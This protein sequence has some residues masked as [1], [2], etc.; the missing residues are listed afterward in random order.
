M[1]EYALILIGN[2]QICPL[3]DE[4]QTIAARYL[5]RAQDGQW[6]SEGEAYLAPFE[7]AEED[8]SA[9]DGHIR[10]HYQDLPIDIAIRPKNELKK[11]LLI[12][13]MDSTIIQQECIDEIADF[14]GLKERIS[15][16]TEQAMRGELD[17]DAAL[18]ERVSLL[19]GIKETALQ[20]VI[21]QKLDL[22][23]GAK[24]LVQTMKA[25]DCYCALVSGGFTFFTKRIAETVGFHTN[26]A[27]QLKIENGELSGEVLEPILGREAKLS[28]LKQFCTE[29]N[30]SLDEAL[31][32]G[33]GAND[34]AMI[35]AAGLGVAFH[36]KPIVAEKADAQINSGDLT[37]LLFM[38]GYNREEFV[39]AD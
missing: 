24:T 27:N 28:A 26:Q 9:I 15:T 32:V 2:P 11:K 21:D 33:D 6:L 10:I 39:A 22:M 35:E 4:D 12:A 23:P 19:K 8:I 1:T 16:I 34:L 29:Q 14:A 30:I 13:D 25:N 18:K 38:Q 7:A 3:T 5:P 20:E 31:A 17:F 37:S 36:A